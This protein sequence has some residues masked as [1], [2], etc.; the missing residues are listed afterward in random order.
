MRLTNTNLLNLNLLADT[1][2]TLVPI[3]KQKLRGQDP[4]K[5]NYKRLLFLSYKAWN[6][7]QSEHFGIRQ[8]RRSERRNQ[9]AKAMI[10]VKLSRTG[11]QK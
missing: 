6:S 10:V 2:A 1:C 11:S 3:P 9:H 5:Y 8:S 4:A 7:G